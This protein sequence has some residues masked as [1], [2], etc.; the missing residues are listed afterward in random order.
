MDKRKVLEEVIAGMMEYYSEYGEGRSMDYMYGFFD[1]VGL[2]RDMGNANAPVQNI[3]HSIR[4]T[5][6]ASTANDGI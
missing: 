5:A 2:V 6:F 1:A 4:Y 3:R